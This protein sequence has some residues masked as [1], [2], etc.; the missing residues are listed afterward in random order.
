M[1]EQRQGRIVE[2]VRNSNFPT[3]QHLPLDNAEPL[4]EEVSLLGEPALEVYRTMWD[5][6]L[7]GPTPEAPARPSWDQCDVCPGAVYATHSQIAAQAG[8]SRPTANQAIDALI[9][10]GY[11]GVIGMTPTKTG[12]KARIYRVFRPEVVPFQQ[13]LVAKCTPEDMNYKPGKPGYEMAKILCRPTSQHY[14]EWSTGYATFAE[15]PTNEVSTYRLGDSEPLEAF[16]ALYG[17]QDTGDVFQDDDDSEDPEQASFPIIQSKPRSTLSLK[18]CYPPVDQ[19]RKLGK[20]ALRVYL[21]MWKSASMDHRSDPNLRKP[22]SLRLDCAGLTKWSYKGM[23][24]QLQICRKTVSR[25]ID[26]LLDNGFITVAG[27]TGEHSGNRHRVYRVFRPEMIE[28]QRHI[29]NMFDDP[30]SVRWREWSK[31]VPEELE[32]G[33]PGESLGEVVGFN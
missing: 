26:K 31:F 24:E 18:G 27:T 5:M 2:A 28:A 16:D 4:L 3:L 12:S 30:P 1:I 13:A 7:Q 9:D 8:V 19:V 23:A 33:H 14:K 17:P 6:A 21:F 15:Y 32:D 20:S 25:A 29:I 10:G 11:I 22:W